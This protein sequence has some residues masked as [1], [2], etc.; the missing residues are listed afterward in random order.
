MRNRKKKENRPI[1]TSEYTY[2]NDSINP[3]RKVARIRRTD[4]ADLVGQAVVAETLL[5]SI[6]TCSFS[7]LLDAS[8][9]VGVAVKIELAVVA[10]NTLYT[11]C[12]KGTRNT[13]RD[14]M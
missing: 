4:T 3:G 2:P 10:T 1:L 9:R 12:W 8:G 7:P 14:T 11:K 5:V 13:H 6:A